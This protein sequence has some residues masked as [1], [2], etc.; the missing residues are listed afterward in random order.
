MILDIWEFKQSCEQL[1]EWT[2]PECKYTEIINL[3]KSWKQIVSSH[4]LSEVSRLFKLFF[5]NG[6]EK[7]AKMERD[8]LHW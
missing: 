2:Y 4:V 3:H 5:E 8:S 6:E 1:Y 7:N